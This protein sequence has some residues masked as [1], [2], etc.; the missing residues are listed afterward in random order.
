MPE[1]MYA[2]LR[3]VVTAAGR[4][5]AIVRASRRSRVGA[6]CAIMALRVLKDK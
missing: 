4:P 2:A 5:T 1:V 3:S 6:V